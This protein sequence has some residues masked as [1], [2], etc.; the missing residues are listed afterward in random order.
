MPSS[1]EHLLQVRRKQ[2]ERERNRK[3]G[4]RV[5][6]KEAFSGGTIPQEKDIKNVQDDRMRVRNGRNI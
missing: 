4:V 3:R 2:R 6:S 1:Y 5:F